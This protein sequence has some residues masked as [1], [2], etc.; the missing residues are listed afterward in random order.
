MLQGCF[1]F[2]A[3]MRPI[4]GWASLNIRIIDRTSKRDRSIVA[5]ALLRGVDE[6]DFS[7]HRFGGFR[8]Q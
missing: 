1:I 5:L 2:E 7:H 6:L 3:E 4:R 8:K